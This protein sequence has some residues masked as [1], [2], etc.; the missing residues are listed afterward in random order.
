MAPEQFDNNPLQAGIDQYALGV[1]VYEWLS[2][3][4]P[5]SGSFEAVAY[6]HV[7]T[8]PP[9]LRGKVPGIS[10]DIEQVVMKALAKNPQQRFSSVKAFAEALEQAI[11]RTIT[12]IPPESTG[13]VLGR[14]SFLVGILTAGLALG[15][16]GDRTISPLLHP[17][18]MPPTVTPTPTPTPLKLPHIFFGHFSEVNTVAW[19][20]NGKFIAS[21]SRDYTAKIWDVTTGENIFTYTQHNN[22]VNT[23]AWSLDG[24]SIASGSADDTVQVW[25]ATTGG[26]AIPY[27][28]HTASVQ[29]LA[30]SPDGTLIA[31]GSYDSTVQVWNPTSG[32]IFVYKGHTAEV[33]A[34][35]WSPDGKLIASGGGKY[36][37]INKQNTD[38]AVQVWEATTGHSILTYKGHLAQVDGLAWSPDGRLIA[39]ASYD[40]TVQVWDIATGG[41]ASTL[42]YRGHSDHVRAV[43]WSPDGKL[44]ASASADRTVQVWNASTGNTL[45]TYTG[46]HNW[47]HTVAWSPDGKLIASGSA[48]QTIQIW[49]VKK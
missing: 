9:S 33:D 19:S 32:F 26:S 16:L 31:S 14:R 11:T 20:P 22:W 8:P 7:H 30:W 46:H 49:E 43:A 48:D 18:S 1:V 27:K 23:V 38:T 37:T 2:G 5:F 34:L 47:V 44:I 6:Q 21:G 35:A 4:C 42:I 41:Q 24:K 36:Q 45:Y 40:N 10:P 15:V 25:D 28:G 12:T 13:R 29:V 17:T 39:S 3:E